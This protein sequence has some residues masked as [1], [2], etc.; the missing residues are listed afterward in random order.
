MSES[1]VPSARALVS[2]VVLAIAVLPA[3]AQD[4]Y[5]LNQ[6]RTFALTFHDANWETL[7]RQNYASETNILADLVVDGT[8]YPDVGV[9]I[10]G[11][12]SYTA[13]PAGSQKFSLKLEMDFV[14]ADQ[15]LYGYDNLNLNNGFHDPTFSREVVYNNF[16]AQFI[17][18][19]RA[20]NVVVTLQGQ[21]W[22]VY[23]NIQQLDKALLRDYFEDNDGLRIGC[24]N[25]P[26]G[27]GLAYNGAN[28][29][30]YTAYQVNEAGGFANPIGELIAVANAL[31]NGV[32]ANWPTTID[33]VFAV[34]PSLWSVVLENMLTDDD[35]YINKGCDF[36]T[37]RDPLDGRLHLLQRDANETFTQI[38]WAWNRNFTATNKPVLSRLINQVPELRQRYLAHYRVA[39]SRMNWAYFGP[40]FAQRQALLDA[41]VQADPK[42]LYTYQLFTQNFTQQVTMPLPGLAGGTIPGLQPFI[43]QRASFLAQTAELV[44]SGPSISAAAASNSTPAPGQSVFI[45]ATVNPVAGGSISGVLLYF[46][47]NRAQT[48]QNTAMF[49]DGAHGDGAAADGIWGAQLPVNGIGGQKVQWY[50]R[51]ASGN[52]FLSQT[53]RPELAERGPGVIEYTTA[54]TDGMRITEFMYDGLGGEFIEFTNRSTQ[55]IDLTGWSMDDS[56]AVPGAFSLSAAGIL[57]PGESVVV[58][59]V[60]AATFRTNWSLG[61]GVKVIGELGVVGVGGNNFGRNDTIHIFNAGRALVD[62]LQYGDQDF[63]GTI[64]TQN[65]SGQAPCIALGQN[66]IA[67]W[68]LSTAGDAY[69]SVTATSGEQGSPGS[70]V[71]IGQCALA[72]G[73]FANGFED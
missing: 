49:D 37:Y 5:D 67:Q 48:Y 40:I 4:L 27:P 32:L 41:A 17:P 58:T 3:A 66:A 1:A 23:N 52:A 59:N 6:L 2:A 47:A 7:L 29:S 72:E 46:R 16:V 10:R 44:A 22:G 68:V 28:A 31:S 42:K 65:R 56:N 36:L 13:L 26:N 38:N 18:N 14:H 60:T 15:D 61:T 24:S 30:G 20:N 43:E 73:V 69:G 57:Q 39:L 8:T 51:A 19:P 33:H 34:D 70:F 9:R 25:N 71:A 54:A 62:R 21:N 12:T 64:R 63:P 45:T 53:Y 11:N 35:S 50:V 55:A